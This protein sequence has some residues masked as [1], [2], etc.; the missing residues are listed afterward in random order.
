MKMIH[1]RPLALALA[2]ALGLL[3]SA[4]ASSTNI[5]RLLADPHR[6]ANKDV[7]LQGD[8]VE[9]TSLLGKGAYKIDDGTGSIWVVSTHGVPRRGARVSVTGQVKDV[10][11][12]GSLFKLPDAV[13]SGLVMVE[14]HH[15]SR[16]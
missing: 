3:A 2:G 16:D 15:K 13:A 4:C 9:S 8:V 12:I 5:A 7:T 6:H 1:V 11:D 14:D 10:G